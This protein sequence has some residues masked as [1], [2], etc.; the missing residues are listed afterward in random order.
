MAHIASVL[1]PHGVG[2][3][4]SISSGCFA[5]DEA[6]K[7]RCAPDGGYADPTCCPASRDVPYMSV[8]TDMYA[9]SIGDRTPDW[10]KNGTR[11]SCGSLMKDEDPV[12]QQY[13][14]WEGPL[15]NTLHS[16][17][18]TVHADRAPQLSP[19]LWLGDCL[20]NGTCSYKIYN[21]Y[22][23]DVYAK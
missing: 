17:L 8:L 6:T 12:T 18:A 13:C 11:G 19:A 3:G 7:A 15:M 5:Y 14:G 16:P 2:L 23:C 1:K 20:D 22:Y 10:S 9:Y 4:N 21:C